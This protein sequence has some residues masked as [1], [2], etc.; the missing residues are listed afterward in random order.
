MYN[1]N[2]KIINP[3]KSI[4]ISNRLYNVCKKKKSV[5]SM[6]SIITAQNDKKDKECTFNPKLISDLDENIFIDNPIKDDVLTNQKV[7]QY[8]KARIQRKLIDFAQSKGGNLMMRIKNNQ[9][10]VKEFNNQPQYESFKFGIERKTNKDTFDTFND[11]KKFSNYFPKKE[12]PL[13]TI[14]V[15]IKE[16]IELL[17]YYKNDDPVEITKKFCALH[18]LGETSN[19]KILAVI[20][21][22]LKDSTITDSN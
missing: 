22:K 5:E 8:E 18:N 1:P 13:F 14:E 3:S 10:L 2:N 19:E 4:E 15:K 21:E 16:K 20:E 6:Q 7:E 17:D 12:T 11:N 9:E